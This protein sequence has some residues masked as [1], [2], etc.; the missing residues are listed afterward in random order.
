[1]LLREPGQTPYDLN[2]R[3]FGVPVRVH[4]TFWLTGVVLGGLGAQFDPMVVLLV[5][6]AIFVSIL[7]H[8]LGHAFV[9][10]YFGGRPWITMYA[11]G[12]LASHVPNGAS[13]R[14]DPTVR[15]AAISLAGPIH[16][17]LLAAAIVAVLAAA[18]R[19]VEFQGVVPRLDFEFFESNPSLAVLTSAM[20]YVNVFWALLNLAPIYP[21][22]GGQVAHAVLARINPRDGLRITLVLS[23]ATSVALA[24][25]VAFAFKTMYLVIFFAYLAFENYQTLQAQNYRRW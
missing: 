22:D 9:I 24:V 3:V 19:R 7:W 10:Q 4:P 6:I 1:M 23:I 15:A 14:A 11:F 5:T 21:L 16:Q 13:R 17:L 20:L 8:E 2:F 18:G 25:Y 12:G